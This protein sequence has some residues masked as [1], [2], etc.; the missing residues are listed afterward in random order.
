MAARGLRITVRGTEGGRRGGVK[1]LTLRAAA[2]VTAAAGTG[3][4]TCHAAR[5]GRRGAGVKTFRSRA[6]GFGA[7]ADG[8][9]P[10]M[11]D[12]ARGGR[13]CG[14]RTIRKPGPA[15]TAAITCGKPRMMTVRGPCGGRR[16]GAV[17]LISRSDGLGAIADGRG[18][19]VN[20]RAAGGRRG[21]ATAAITSREAAFG[22]IADGFGPVVKDRAGEGRRAGVRTTSTRGAA[23]TAAAVA[24]GRMMNDLAANDRP[25]IATGQPP[26]PGA[27]VIASR[28]RT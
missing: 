2:P 18:P 8:F 16:G 28:L 19:T 11:K 20:D 22:A 14:A 13:G 6:A 17:T 10:A 25:G 9:G 27:A 3:L 23:V 1:L 15:V 21:A 7:A 26:C 24:R 5:G 12:R 4:M